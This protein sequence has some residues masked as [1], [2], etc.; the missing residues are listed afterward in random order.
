M[1]RGLARWM[2]LALALW[3]V[4]IVLITVPVVDRTAGR[5]T[6]V[7]LEPWLALCRRVTPEA[8]QTQGNVPLGL[9]WLLAGMLV[10]SAALAALGMGVS[11][12]ARG[13]RTPRRTV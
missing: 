12:L 7:V 9:L 8:W 1:T 10:G 3:A 11:V 2:L 13:R 5:L 4:W 6:E